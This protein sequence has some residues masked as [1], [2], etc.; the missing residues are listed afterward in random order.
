MK[1]CVILNH[2]KTGNSI[3]LNRKITL[4]NA[5]DLTSLL[6]KDNILDA[7]VLTANGSHAIIATSL[8]S[9]KRVKKSLE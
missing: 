9:R 5:S 6:H 1:H 4:G 7:S 3:L 8:Q 2:N